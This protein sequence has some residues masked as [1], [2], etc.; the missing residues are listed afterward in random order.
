MSK[1]LLDIT[2]VP[3][4]GAVG[5]GLR[6]SE[7]F[8][9]TIQGEGRYIGY[10]AAFLRVKGCTLECTWCD[11]E[12]VWRHGSTF[13]NSELLDLMQENKVIE[14]LKNGAH[15]VLTGGS[16]L[17]QQKNLANFITDFL[18][19]FDFKPFIEVE[20]ECTLEIKPEFY[21]WVDHWN[22][23]PK[24]SNSLQEKGKRYVPANIKALSTGSTSA[25]FKFVISKE[26]DWNEIEEDFLQTGLIELKDIILMPEGDTQEKLSKSREKVVLLAIDK[27]VRFSDRL[28][29][30]IWNKRT[31]V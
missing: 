6:V 12:T 5:S 10:P 1:V 8:S 17:L 24:L 19:R 13:T 26:S 30:T 2:S 11:S 29:I 15:L 4:E 3:R 9:H 16:P 20:S 31:G 28:H 23:S 14:F 27:A 7:F 18:T 25:D 21:K 22:C